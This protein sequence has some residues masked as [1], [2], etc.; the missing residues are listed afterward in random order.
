MGR[1]GRALSVDP[2]LR[3]A[4][5]EQIDAAVDVAHLPTLLSALCTV[6]PP[7][8]Q[9]AVPFRPD[10]YAFLDPHGGLSVDQR[11]GARRLARETLRAIRDAEAT[12]VAPARAAVEEQIRPYFD[13]GELD[14]YLLLA[15]EELAIVDPDPR[16]PGWRADRPAHGGD[17][18]VAI[19]GAGMSGLLAGH[20]LRQVGIPFV[21]YEKNRDLGGT[22]FENTYPGC[23]VDVPSHLYTYTCGRD[24]DFADHYSVQG[25]VL[26]YFRRFAEDHGLIDHIRFGCEVQSMA[27]D[28]RALRWVL[29][30]RSDRGI[31]EVRSSVV[32]SAVG[33][34]NR[35]SIP[36]LPGRDRFQG[37]AFHSAE[38]DHDAELDGRRIAVIGTGA[39][40]LQVVPALAERAG[41]LVVFQRQPAWLISTP[42]LRRPIEE[43]H[44]WLFRH[45]PTYQRWYRFWRLRQVSDPLHPFARHDP[46]W[47]DQER[48]VSAANDRMRHRLASY[49]EDQFAGQPDR[50]A[51]LTPSYP[52]F[53][54]RAVRDDGG[55]AAA[56]GAD[57][58]RLET[59]GID[60]ITE[61]GIRTVDG[62]HNQFDVI[63]YATG[64][65]ASRFLTPMTVTGRDGR[66]LHEQWAGDP[67]AYLGI[68]V[69]HFPNLFLLYGPN[70]NIVVNGS[71]I[72][73]SE[74][75]VSY[76]L[77]GLRLLAEQG[78]A[79]EVRA[80]VH[81]AFR[82]EVD[83]G[84]EGMAWGCSGVRSWYKSQSG[85]VSQN[86]HSTVLEYWRRTRRFDKENYRHLDRGVADGSRSREGAAHA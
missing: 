70:T 56:L 5:D 55:W 78:G 85:R 22:W 44:R 86:W 23:R 20:R 59:A 68:T 36:E 17:L 52:P 76:V 54:K 46:S 83:R 1:N 19:V 43:P 4:G 49:L 69:P 6:L 21:I 10:R 51:D 8:A 34:L 47:P 29:R 63:V 57:H 31:E 62:R 24:E 73:F 82:R 25:D 64:F 81:D 60:E 13:P 66:D 77:D 37:R 79:V 18:T 15:L 71:A 16:A 53:A 7:V 58:V 33:Q 61:T 50:L 80:D 84:N 35:P 14:D 30:V 67:S 42:E 2:E 72:F 12:P 75:E 40:G 74:C 41:R 48:S 32:L 28:D 39:S 65:R 9:R 45:L 3:S 11:D 26:R 38:W 27:F